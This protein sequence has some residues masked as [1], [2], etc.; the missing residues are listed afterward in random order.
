LNGII[1]LRSDTVTRPTPEMYE[2]MARAPLGDDVL[3]DDPTVRELEELA[4]HKTGKDAAVFVPSGTM[5]NQIAIACHCQ[6]G[7]AL[8]A[9]QESHILFYEVGGPA[10]HAGAI[11][12]T[13]PSDRGVMD[14]EEIARRVTSATIHTPGTRLLCLENTHNRAGG[15]I[16]PL[17]RMREYRA[18]ADR[19]GLKV[20]LDGARVFNAAV[21]LSV[22][23]R[24]ITRWVDTVSVCLSKGLRAP[25]GSVLCGPA[26][27]ID[28]ARLWRKRMGGGMR[29][30]GI[31]AACGILSLTRYV[32][33][34]AEDH[35]NAR[36]LA[37]GLAELPGFEVDLETVQTNIVQVGL[38]GEAA[39]WQARLHAEGV[40]CLPTGPRRIRL[41]THADVTK[42]DVDR[43]LAIFRQLAG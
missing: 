11:T 29:Q 22:D 41:V 39:I 35:A 8:I 10:I 1:D 26:D 15:T 5:S 31:L 18:V 42:S 19:F 43:A 16:I 25:V 3:G 36:R 34:L 17:E 21:A 13:L 38:P 27:F 14:P 32:D 9:E 33:R 37:E 7:D 23:V 28:R 4:A 6:R 12:W 40:W 2:A 30:A 20:H 24:E